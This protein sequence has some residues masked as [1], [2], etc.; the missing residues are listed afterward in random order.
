MGMKK[1]RLA[2][3]SLFLAVG[4]D[5]ISNTNTV[6]TDDLRYGSIQIVDSQGNPIDDVS[7]TIIN[8]R[9][10]LA[11][12]EGIENPE[13][14]EWCTDEYTDFKAHTQQ[15]GYH[16]IVSTFN[17][18]QED[19]RDGDE[20]EVSFDYNGTSYSEVF[21][22]EADECNLQGLNGPETIVVQ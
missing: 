12:C 1:L 16:L 11:A 13:R 18:T 4:C 17:I 2:V 5:V 22:V 10:G 9:T 21:T 19:V 14:K 6:C 8:Q 7:L 20:I 15:A 3:L